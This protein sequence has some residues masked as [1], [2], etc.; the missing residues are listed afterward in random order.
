MADLPIADEGWRGGNSLESKGLLGAQELF[1]G[2]NE[3]GG[4]L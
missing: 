3:E 2:V 4:R 1:L